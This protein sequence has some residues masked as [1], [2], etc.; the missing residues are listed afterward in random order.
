[1]AQ[2]A[3]ERLSDVFIERY[4]LSISALRWRELNSTH[5]DKLSAVCCL[6]E[7][8][9]VMLARDLPSRNSRFI[10]WSRGTRAQLM[11]HRTNVP[12]ATTRGRDSKYVYN[13][14]ILKVFDSCCSSFGPDYLHNWQTNHASNTNDQYLIRDWDAIYGATYGNR[15]AC[16][17]L[18]SLSIC[19]YSAGLSFGF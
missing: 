18:M 15:C 11:V 4:R 3:L 7:P 9:W 6:R 8:S 5:S 10:D 17:F 1:M 14:T 12:G 19:V 2:E 16:T 13:I